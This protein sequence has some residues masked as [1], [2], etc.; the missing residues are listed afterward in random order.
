[1][2][3]LAV[4]AVRTSVFRQRALTIGLVAFGGMVL[5]HLIVVL[6]F[7]VRSLYPTDVIWSSLPF[8]QELA[9][10]LLIAAYTGAL[11]IPVGWMLVR[12]APLW[13]F[14]QHGTRRY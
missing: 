7:S 13:R 3:C 10:R 8:G 11:A 6:V 4:L 5:M 9:R 1:M 12:S 2:C 14:Q